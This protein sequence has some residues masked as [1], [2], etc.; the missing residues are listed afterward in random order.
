MAY[1]IALEESGNPETLIKHVL[2]IES[3]LFPREEN[4]V[5]VTVIEH[6]IYH[7]D[8]ALYPEIWYTF[9]EETLNDEDLFTELGVTKENLLLECAKEIKEQI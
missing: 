4:Y 9:D 8:N 6:Q 1:T 2:Q 7:E 5:E 3:E